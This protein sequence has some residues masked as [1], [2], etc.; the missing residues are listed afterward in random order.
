M[1]L[2]EEEEDEET[3]DVVVVSRVQSY[4]EVG[5]DD[6]AGNGCNQSQ[7]SSIHPRC[8]KDPETVCIHCLH[9]HLL[10]APRNFTLCG[11]RRRRQRALHLLP[12]PPRSSPSRRLFCC[13]CE[14]QVYDNVNAA[15]T[16]AIGLFAVQLCHAD[17]ESSEVAANG[18]LHVDA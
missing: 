18:L 15:A 2:E 6:G 14:D 7:G 16:A 10:L 13:V 11:R 8:Y 5:G 4:V 1:T 17:E 3:S 12:P 9:H